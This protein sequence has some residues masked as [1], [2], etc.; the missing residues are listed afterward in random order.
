MTIRELLTKVESE[1]ELIGYSTETDSYTTI[2]NDEV[3]MYYDY[4]VVNIYNP[5]V[6]NVIV[7]EFYLD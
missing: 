2:P 1:V 6:P 5:N 3:E 7:I 4:S